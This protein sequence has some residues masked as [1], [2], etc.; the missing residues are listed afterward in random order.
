M[1]RPYDHLAVF[2]DKAFAPLESVWLR[3]RRTELAAN[4]RPGDRILEIG[5]GTG[6]NFGSYPDP[7]RA[8]A[9][10]ISFPM[11]ERAMRRPD[12]PAIV[13]AD[14]QA[15][16][17][18]E[19]LFDA[20][21]ATLV[22]CSV[23]DP[24]LG[25]SEAYRVIKPGGR[26]HLIEHVRPDGIAGPLFDGLNLVTVALIDDHFNRQTASTVA[27]VGFE[28]EGLDRRLGGAVIMLS[29]VKPKARR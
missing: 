9:I 16:P 17:F 21:F 13:Q 22:F 12:R 11:I 7:S 6:A 5:A 15:L 2:Y 27:Q 14:A 29:A 3:D 4:L 20:A 26:L 23:P 19:D 1:R 10:E 25:L 28:I 8:T 24:L 18:P